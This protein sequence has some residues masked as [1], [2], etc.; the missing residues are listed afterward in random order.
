M[1]R[2]TTTYL[3]FDNFVM[4]NFN[5]EDFEVKVQAKGRYYYQPCVMYFS[6]GTGQ[7]EDEDFEVEKFEIV[8]VLDFITKEEVKELEDNEDFK[9]LVE[10]ALYDA[11]E[12]GTEEWEF[13]EEPDYEP[14]EPWED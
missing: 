4:V 8:K 11:W 13:P 2:S 14:Q 12:K 5:G 10:E 3:S 1:N 7:P 6:D 9:E